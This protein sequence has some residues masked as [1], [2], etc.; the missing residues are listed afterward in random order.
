MQSMFCYPKAAV[1]RA[2]KVQEVILRAM[3]K[4]ITWWQ[5]AEI[6]GISDRQMRRW[7]VRS[8]SRSQE[9][10]VPLLAAQCNCKT[11]H[12]ICLTL[13]IDFEFVPQYGCG[14][15]RRR[16]SLKE[17]RERLF[18]FQRRTRFPRRARHDSR[19]RGLSSLYLFR[20]PVRFFQG[21]DRR[22]RG[23]FAEEEV[24]DIWADSGPPWKCGAL[25]LFRLEKCCFLDRPCQWVT[26]RR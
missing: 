8:W 20:R 7:H 23:N 4:K 22:S 2:M 11:L 9:I 10:A 1:E 16:P 24:C 13:H 15:V 17:V 18:P 26:N 14:P 12:A 21:H 5:A 3:A 19:A 25:P 6:I